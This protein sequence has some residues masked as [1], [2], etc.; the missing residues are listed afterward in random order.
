MGLRGCDNPA[1]NFKLD[2]CPESSCQWTTGGT[3]SA[4]GKIDSS[5]LK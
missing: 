2:E 3:D 4:Y 1:V 5:I